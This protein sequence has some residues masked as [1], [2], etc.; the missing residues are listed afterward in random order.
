MKKHPFG[1]F[2]LENTYFSLSFVS[3]FCCFG[4]VHLMCACRT[5]PCC[6]VI[7]HC[8]GVFSI[9]FA[10]IDMIVGPPGPSTP[11]H[12]KYSTD[13]PK[14][15]PKNSPRLGLTRLSLSSRAYPLVHYL[16]S[17]QAARN[18]FLARPTVTRVTS[19][20]Y[21]AMWCSDL[22]KVANILQQL[23]SYSQQIITQTQ[24]FKVSLTPFECW[25][26]L[27]TCVYTYTECTK[28]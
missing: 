26:A 21:I 2:V 5:G 22:I 13:G 27:Y 9:H 7:L 18:L 28:H 4:F 12:K 10:R 19:G 8:A 11:R 3:W 1:K 20:V 25:S 17:W 23:F 24:W 6:A 15:S 14:E 16:F